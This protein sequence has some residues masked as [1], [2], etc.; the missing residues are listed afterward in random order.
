MNNHKLFDQFNRN[1]VTKV[2][3]QLRVI[4]IHLIR[5][6]DEYL[7]IFNNDC[8][9]VQMKKEHLIVSKY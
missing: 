8:A 7:Y 4:E 5:V 3:I 1:Q 9:I 2:L 6:V